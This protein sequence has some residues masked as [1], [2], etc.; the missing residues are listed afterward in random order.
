MGERIHVRNVVG[1]YPHGTRTFDPAN[2][3][4]EVIEESRFVRVR[5]DDSSAPEAWLEVTLE[6]VEEARHEPA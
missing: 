2:I 5:I 1:R 4:A 6:I 3:D